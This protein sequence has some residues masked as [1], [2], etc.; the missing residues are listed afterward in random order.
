MKSGDKVLSDV[1]ENEG[2]RV[3]YVEIGAKFFYFYKSP[4]SHKLCQIKIGKSPHNF[5]SSNNHIY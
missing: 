5:V 1:D 4:T 3:S 2:L